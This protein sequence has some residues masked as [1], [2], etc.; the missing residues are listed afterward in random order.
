M[1][2]LHAAVI[3]KTI[4]VLFLNV[5]DKR[6]GV[7]KYVVELS[8]VKRVFFFEFALKPCVVFPILQVVS[9]VRK[10][11]IKPTLNIKLFDKYVFVRVFLSVENHLEI[12]DLA[13]LINTQKCVRKGLKVV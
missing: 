8:G 7:Q 11:L 12:T 10:V 4:L 6:V 2:L 3:D 1:L 5:L 13:K 9:W